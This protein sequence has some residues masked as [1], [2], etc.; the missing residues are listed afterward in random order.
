MMFD[1]VT[2]KLNADPLILSALQEDITSGDVS[3]NSVMP[4]GRLGKLTLSAGRKALSAGCRFLSGYL[5]FWKKR[6]QQNFLSRMEM[7]SGKDS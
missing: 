1:P 2:M 6:R 4:Q 5:R 3:A 7:L